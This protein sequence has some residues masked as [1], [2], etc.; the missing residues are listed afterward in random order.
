VKL[1][2]R[3][4]N[5]LVI[6]LVKLLLSRNFSKVWMLISVTTKLLQQ[7]HMC[8]LSNRKIRKSKC[9]FNC[10]FD[11]TK[12]LAYHQQ[13]RKCVMYSLCHHTLGWLGEKL[14]RFFDVI[15]NVP[16]LTK[17]ICLIN[18]LTSRLTKWILL[19]IFGIFFKL[20]H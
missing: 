15:R 20:T 12:N 13:K 19:Y 6:S 1:E 18:F 3:Q 5:S 14:E 2:I 11:L 10:C 9:S 17:K 4:I 7:L 16:L 8:V